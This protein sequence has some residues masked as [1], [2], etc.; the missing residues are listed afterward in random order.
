MNTIER[1]SDPQK[2]IVVVCD[3]LI[4]ALDFYTKEFG[5]RIEMI[6]PADSPR[7][8]RLSGY[9]IDVRLERSAEA[10]FHDAGPELPRLEPSLVIQHAHNRK[11][12]TGRAGMQYRDLIPGRLGG[13]YIASHIRIP[14][15]GPVPDY[16]HHHHVRFQMIYCYNGWV[17]VV[18]EDQGPPFVM[19]V[20]DCVLQPPHI[21]HRVLECSDQM[22]VIE[23]TCPAEHETLVDHEM[24]LPTKEF[25][26]DRDFN[27][28]EF[29]YHECRNAQW[30]AGPV[31]GFESRDLGIADATDGIASAIVLR[32]I[33][34]SLN[35][36]LNVSS[37]F[38][39][40]FVLQGELKLESEDDELWSLS[41]G[42]SFVIPVGMPLRVVDPSAE[43]EILQVTSD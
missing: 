21:R 8:V 27:G 16:V 38:F 7:M 37:E 14:T 1:N 3:D 15:G 31:R 35:S 28:Q 39:F 43:L 9:G 25:Q 5:F 32:P 40:N 36:D 23:I 24:R 6:F 17:K 30:L 42:D 34:K 26:P 33:E 19:H 2:E 29:V 10:M 20:G 4:G 41:G 22:E 13:R 11:W 12:G 18:F